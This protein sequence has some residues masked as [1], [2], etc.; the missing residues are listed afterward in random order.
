LRVVSLA[1][2]A[3][4]EICRRAIRPVLRIAHVAGGLGFSVVAGGKRATVPFVAIPETAI[5]TSD[6]PTIVAD[7]KQPLGTT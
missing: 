4:R 1:L 3:Q 2:L 7:M 6:T 5:L